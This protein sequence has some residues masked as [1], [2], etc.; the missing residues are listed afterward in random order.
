M[1]HTIL[2]STTKYN[3]S[4]HVILSID[5]CTLYTIILTLLCYSKLYLTCIFLLLKQESW[6][7]FNVSFYYIENKGLSSSYACFKPYLI[8]SCV[9]ISMVF[10]LPL[11]S[12]FGTLYYQYIFFTF[13]S[14]TNFNGC[15][16]E[17][18][19]LVVLYNLNPSYFS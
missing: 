12:L 6:R 10:N 14:I 5:Y 19:N 2:H 7:F 18:L 8:H 3:G 17:P 4:G 13:H 1:K 9:Y 11:F 16:I 15:G